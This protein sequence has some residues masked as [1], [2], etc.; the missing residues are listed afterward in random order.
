MSFK[1]ELICQIREAFPSGRPPVRPVTGHRCGEC[2]AID[3]LLG[4]R[5]W[6]DVAARFPQDC[7]HAFPLLLP[8]A[9]AYYL[10]AFMTFELQS[11]GTMAGLSVADALN[12]G[13]L[14]PAQFGPEQRNAIRRWGRWYFRSYKE[15]PPP[16]LTA[17]WGIR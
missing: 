9:M 15:R 17:T 12:K 11:P 16:S 13:D 14:L 1:Q 4:D 10:P 3:E 8:A 7:H 2:D 6:S 5:T